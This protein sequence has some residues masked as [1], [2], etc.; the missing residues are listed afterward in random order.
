MSNGGCETEM[1]VLISRDPCMRDEMSWFV[2]ISAASEEG[3]RL[4]LHSTRARINPIFTD[5][6]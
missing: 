4:T 1:D 5:E 3:N 2:L 6:N